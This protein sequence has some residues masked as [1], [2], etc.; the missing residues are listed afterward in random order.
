VRPAIRSATFDLDRHVYDAIRAGASGFLL[1]DAARGRLAR[2]IRDIAAGETP[3]DPAVTRRL[4]E[5]FARRPPPGAEPPPDLA[6]LSER[7]L[8]VLRVVA[9]GRSNQ[10]VATDL[11][12]SVATV[13]T[14]VASILRKLDERDRVQLVVRAYESGLIEPGVAG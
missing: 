2:A 7:E 11:H 13:K 6:E 3:L 4:V 12:L 10:E 5:K 8:D 14:H 1:K 9:R